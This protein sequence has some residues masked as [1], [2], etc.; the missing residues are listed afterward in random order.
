VGRPA[1]RAAIVSSGDEPPMRMEGR[2]P[3]LRTARFATS[4]GSPTWALSWARWLTAAR[5][6]SEHVGG[7]GSSSG[8][9]WSC[10]QSRRK[11]PQCPRLIA[12]ETG[13]AS[14]YT[15]ATSST[16]ATSRHSCVAM[17]LWYTSMCTSLRCVSPGRDRAVVSASVRRTIRA[18]R[19]LA[20]ERLEF[21]RENDDIEGGS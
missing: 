16:G 10:S 9:T 18:V 5:Y 1:S 15:W 3:R 13:L 17:S 21:V 11:R 8:L 7:N 19:R 14:P 4:G 20:N 6:R 12:S 2:R